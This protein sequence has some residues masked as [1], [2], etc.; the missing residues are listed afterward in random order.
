MLA[1][2]AGAALG[3]A[4]SRQLLDL[5]LQPVGTTFFYAPAE[6]FTAH[7]RVAF[8]AAG[9]ISW[10]VVL[11]QLFSFIA[12]G[13]YPSERRVLIWLLP[14]GTLLFV[15][16]VV[17]GYLTMLPLVLMW[18]SR[19]ASGSVT[20]AIDVA[21]YTSFA[22][23]TML[24]LGLIFQLPLAVAVLSRAGVVTARGLAGAR[25]PVVL[26]AVVAAAVLTPPDVVS[27]LLMAGPIVVLYEV[28]VII[29][30]FAGGRRDQP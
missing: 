15:F 7:L 9:P 21:I 3:L 29:A 20:P 4:F 27:Q 11:Y 8:I 23:R 17:F 10:P 24:P 22:L 12:P 13:L 25:R 30:R 2:A 18:L 28:S 19:F 1:F 16:G 14:A 26:A 5:L 6:A